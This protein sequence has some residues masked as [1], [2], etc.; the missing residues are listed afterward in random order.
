MVL[1]VQITEALE[2]ITLT[3]LELSP[4]PLI[5]ALL[6]PLYSEV[7]SENNKLFE[8]LM[9]IILEDFSLF[10]SPSIQSD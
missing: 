9:I 4:S 10:C 1:V 8:L 6:S 2:V 5:S 3:A 7:S